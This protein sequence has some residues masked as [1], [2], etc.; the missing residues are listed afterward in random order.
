MEQEQQASDGSYFDAFVGPQLE[1]GEEYSA[2]ELDDLY[3]TGPADP[4]ATYQAFGHY[5]EDGESVEEYEEEEEQEAE[6]AEEEQN[7]VEITPEEQAEI[8]AQDR[9]SVV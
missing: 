3:C 2:T 1:P 4:E 5:T 6:C 8:D 9:K 7:L